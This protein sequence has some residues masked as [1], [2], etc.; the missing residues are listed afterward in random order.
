MGFG[1]SIKGECCNG[2]TFLI[3]SPQNRKRKYSDP[4]ISWNKPTQ[5][6]YINYDC[7]LLAV[8]AAYMNGDGGTE[9][10]RI[11]ASLNLRNFQSTAK[12]FD[13]TS[14]NFVAQIIIQEAR[15]A[16]KE[17]MIDE[18]HHSFS[19]KYP[20]LDDD[21]WHNFNELLIKTQQKN[22]DEG[23][24][25]SDSSDSAQSQGTSS[26]DGQFVELT[27]ATDIWVGKSDLVEE[28]MTALQVI[29]F[30]L[31]L[32]LTKFWTMNSSVFPA[33]YAI[34]PKEWVALSRTTSATKTLAVMQKPWKQAPQH[35]LLHESLINSMV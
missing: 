8:L 20:L 10:R 21:D 23:A 22:G 27:V 9:V 14:K 25:N 1:T 5:T 3:Q 18:I 34:L 28:D 2:H 13:K 12:V 7:N 17:A 31:V 11:A 24:N 6:K 16:A 32:K 33:T 26:A 35:L 29:C 4:S 15:R 19:H 30:L